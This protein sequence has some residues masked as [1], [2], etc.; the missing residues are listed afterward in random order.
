VGPAVTVV[1]SLIVDAEKRGQ[2]K[3]NGHTSTAPCGCSATVTYFPGSTSSY[4]LA[5]VRCPA[6][7]KS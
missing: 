6:H 2:R 3:V 4:R 1:G 7:P 5:L